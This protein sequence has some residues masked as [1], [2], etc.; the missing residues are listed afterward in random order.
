[1]LSVLQSSRVLVLPALL[2]VLV[3]A[4]ALA[5][6]EPASRAAPSYG[7]HRAEMRQR[8]ARDNARL[9]HQYTRPR[10]TPRV[11]TPSTPLIVVP[12]QVIRE[13]VGEIREGTIIASEVYADLA[14]DETVKANAE[15]MK[16]LEEI[17]RLH[18]EILGLCGQLDQDAAGGEGQ[19]AHVGK[20]CGDMHALLEKALTEHEKLYEA[21]GETEP[22]APIED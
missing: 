20:C 22:L 3:A 8:S 7:R 1:M 17:Q 11:S 10:A 9:L 5:Q 6:R 14:Q 13:H 21:L 2:V 18:Q 4:D 12:P 15:A 19:P 16:H